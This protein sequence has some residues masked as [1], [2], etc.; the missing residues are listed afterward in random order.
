ML[1][2]TTAGT[3]WVSNIDYKIPDKY[4][5]YQNYPNPFNPWT[6]IKYDIP[7]DGFVTIKIYDML[8]REITELVGENEKAGFYSILFNGSNLS[9]GMYLYKIQAGSYSQTKKMV[10]IK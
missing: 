5:L 2:T 7:K 9:S 3:I 4:I 1:K 6:M 8:G 10:L